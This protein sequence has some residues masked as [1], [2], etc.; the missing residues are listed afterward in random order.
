MG[1]LLSYVQYLSHAGV[2]LILLHKSTKDSACI[3]FFIAFCLFQIIAYLGSFFSF[4][5]SLRPIPEQPE[6]CYRATFC[7]FR[8]LVGL[9][10]NC[11]L[12]DGWPSW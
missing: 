7:L 4:H 1:C 2:Q 8:K 10:R 11:I 12:E 5:P 3:F 6:V 9:Q